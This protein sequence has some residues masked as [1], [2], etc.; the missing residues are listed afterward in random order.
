MI[1][2]KQKNSTDILTERMNA[3]FPGGER[4]TKSIG[5]NEMPLTISI[6]E[7]DKSL[8]LSR[9]KR[10]ALYDDIK[11][12]IR[13]KGLD[14][15]P[16]ITKMPGQDAY[17]IL[18]GGN[19]RLQI[20]KEL[21]QETGDKKFYY[22]NCIFRPWQGELKSIVGHLIE[23]GLRDDYTFIEKSIGILKAKNLYESEDG[24]NKNLSSRELSELLKKDGY[25]ISH[26][27]ISKMLNTME[28]L[29]PYMP[30][31]LELGLS[32]NQVEK[33]L[34]LR[35][36]CE[37]AYNQNVRF[38][39]DL[40][41]IEGFN[42]IL[43]SIDTE[44]TLYNF[45]HL[46]DEMFGF[47]SNTWGVQYNLL[48]L[49]FENNEQ[50]K[51][52]STILHQKPSEPINESNV[53]E[54]KVFEPINES[55]VPETEVSEPINENNV[56]GTKSSES[57]L[58]SQDLTISS[59]ED[60]SNSPSEI[61][62]GD[63]ENKETKILQQVEEEKPVIPPSGEIIVEEAN[64]ETI[65]NEY[66]NATDF[67]EIYP[68]NYSLTLNLAESGLPE[69]KPIVDIWKLSEGMTNHEYIFSDI[70]GHVHDIFQELDID[71]K[72]M[73]LFSIDREKRKT[74]IDF[75]PLSKEDATNVI[76]Q[77]AYQLLVAIL[78]DKPVNIQNVNYLIT[79]FNDFVVIKFL[80]IIRLKRVYD[81]LL[82]EYLKQ[83]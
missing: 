57:E 38:T 69:K 72:T 49:I 48:E 10:N 32:R 3:G 27:L 22:I 47:F 44:P 66:K 83:K 75:N 60:V 21:Y 50:G 56:S 58:V 53:P 42:L 7:L 16:V 71:K 46:K 63:Q 43:T 68:R 77:T 55:N 45:E 1:E 11:A 82:Q 78:T 59:H 8:V 23:N 79:N 6:D 30:Q 67:T 18:D 76:K 15:A 39:D 36:S 51:K 14:H 31:V 26:V 41:F 65:V 62:Y 20:L 61:V 13:E 80:R 74:V 34:L 52:S 35:K 5:I 29:Y 12:S 25:P 70:A 73:D 24:N 17:V 40:S 28:Y 33:I 64:L 19:T 2:T 4:A 37:E 9:K 81:E 54:T